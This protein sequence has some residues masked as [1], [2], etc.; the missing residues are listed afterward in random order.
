VRDS[1]FAE[2][3]GDFESNLPLRVDALDNA[4]TEDL[5][6]SNF[7]SE[8]SLAMLPTTIADS[9]RHH[10]VRNSLP[11]VTPSTLPAHD[12]I[13]PR[14]MNSNISAL[15]PAGSA[16]RARMGR[17]SVSPHLAMPTNAGNAARIKNLGSD[18]LGAFVL[19]ANGESR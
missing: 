3:V 18:N 6:V 7:P 2:Q 1:T 14:I 4:T 15:H 11:E 8:F 5:L 10:E 9:C 17:G 13:E 16:L 19:L 12:E